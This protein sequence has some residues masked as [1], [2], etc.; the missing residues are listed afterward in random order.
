MTLLICAPYAAPRGGIGRRFIEGRELWVTAAV[1]L[2][3]VCAGLRLLDQEGLWLGALQ[4]VPTLFLL[5]ALAAAGDAA[6]SSYVAGGETPP[7]VAVALYDELVRNPPERFSRT[8]PARRAARPPAAREARPRQHR[9]ARA[10]A[11]RRLRDEPPA[12]RSG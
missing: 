12:A 9:R 2:V 6:V 10:R 11:G 5:L 1:A 7:A 8:A 4:F 3:A